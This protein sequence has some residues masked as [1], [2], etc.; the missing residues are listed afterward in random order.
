MKETG[1]YYNFSNIRYA[2]PPIGKLRF[3]EPVPPKGRNT[4]INDGQHSAICPQASPSWEVIEGQYILGANLST[5][6][7]ALAAQESRLPSIPKPGPK[8]SEDCLFLDVISPVAAY[9][10][11]KSKQGKHNGH[12]KNC[13]G[14]PSPYSC[15]VCSREMNKN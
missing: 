2:A 6:E 1:Q 13:T 14:G 4:T 5:L 12:E 3:A 15:T 7:A 8:E 10:Q 11:A 9:S